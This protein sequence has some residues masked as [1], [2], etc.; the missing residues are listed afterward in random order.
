MQAYEHIMATMIMLSKKTKTSDMLTLE[1]NLEVI[2]R[3]GAYFTYPDSIRAL[4]ALSTGGKAFRQPSHMSGEAWMQFI[5]GD[6][7]KASKNGFPI[8]KMYIPEGSELKAADEPTSLEVARAHNQELLKTR[9]GQ[10]IYEHLRQDSHTD[11]LFQGYIATC[12]IDEN[13]SG[14][15]AGESYSLYGVT[16]KAGLARFNQTGK[17]VPMSEFREVVA[18]TQ[19]LTTLELFK[20]LREAYPG[21]TFEQIQDA[22]FASYDE[23]YPEPMMNAKKYAVPNPTEQSRILHTLDTGDAEYYE[24][25]KSS[26]VEKGAFKNID[27]VNMQISGLICQ[28]T[29]LDAEQKDR[30]DVERDYI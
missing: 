28:I 14:I 7:L 29:S 4:V 23:N 17:I 18:I 25:L 1:N 11:R 5:I 15:N 22:V 30:F 12:Y 19:Q 27:D 21:I 9:E 26:L 6:E 2:R 10:A 13:E 20:K 24:R 16:T 8:E 3:Y